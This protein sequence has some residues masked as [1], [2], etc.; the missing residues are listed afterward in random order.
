MY[1]NEHHDRYSI[2]KYKLYNRRHYKHSLKK[3]VKIFKNQG[4]ENFNKNLIK[5]T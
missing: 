2:K 3:Y 5:N 4:N 1:P